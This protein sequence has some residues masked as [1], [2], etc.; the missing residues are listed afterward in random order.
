MGDRRDEESGVA[1]P[2]GRGSSFQWPMQPE[3][4]SAPLPNQSISW[5]SEI[6]FRITYVNGK[7]LH[8]YGAAQVPCRR[9]DGVGRKEIGAL[10]SILF[11]SG[12][13][14]EPCRVFTK[15]VPS[16]KVVIDK[17][18]FEVSYH[19]CRSDSTET[20]E[21]FCLGIICKYQFLTKFRRFS[22]SFDEI[23][24]VSMQ[25]GWLFCHPTG[26]SKSNSCSI[27]V[28]NPIFIGSRSGCSQNR[29]RTIS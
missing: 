7:S 29:I 4:H 12:Q 11:L 16:E 24:E 23:A 17:C 14:S 10:L 9:L 28:E 19:N 13:Q 2:T 27:F 6:L 21:L 3:D 5:A 26:R 8:A 1:A 20:P 25:I 18:V 15:K 22:A